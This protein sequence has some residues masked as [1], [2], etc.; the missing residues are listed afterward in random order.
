MANFVS[1]LVLLFE[2]S[3]RPGDVI[4]LDGRISEVEKISLRATTVRTLT[5]EE[6][7]VPNNNFTTN[8]VKNFTKSERLVQVKVPLGVSYK[9]DPELVRQLAIETSLLHP[10][11]LADPPPILLFHGYGDSSLDFNLLVST[12][13]PELTLKIRSDLYYMLWEKLAENKIEIPFPQ[14]DLN[15]GNGWEKLATDIQTS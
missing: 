7:I 11:V 14:R 2:Q 8:Q 9:S 13:Q 12:N 6:L 3:L 5:N 4:E 1:G 10:Q 15:L